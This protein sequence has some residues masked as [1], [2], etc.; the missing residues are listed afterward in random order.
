[1]ACVSVSFE[2]ILDGAAGRVEAE[3]ARCWLQ[4]D[5]RL[6]YT[7]PDDLVATDPHGLDMRVLSTSSVQSKR[8]KRTS[9]AH[10][11]P[12]LQDPG[13]AGA[14]A[15]QPAA[16]LHLHR[17]TRL[18]PVGPHAAGKPELQRSSPAVAARRGS[19]LLKR[20]AVASSATAAARQPSVNLYSRAACMTHGDAIGLAAR[21]KARPAAEFKLPVGWRAYGPPGGA[22][23]APV[24]P[25][26]QQRNA[27]A[28][29]A[30]KQQSQQGVAHQQD[31]AQQEQQ[32][33]SAEGLVL[34]SLQHVR[35]V[36]QGEVPTPAL[37][38][39]WL[40]GTAANPQAAAGWAG[41]AAAHAY[42]LGLCRVR[43]TRVEE[44]RRQMRLR[45]ALARG[46][47]QGDAPRARQHA[48]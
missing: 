8:R 45:L 41:A 7:P 47:P 11:L 12:A 23:P 20:K 31:S 29:R 9:G 16:R 43:V 39:R 32:Y 18:A 17:P 44:D 42:L 19:D 14:C 38:L 33:I 2:D 40:R 22:S 21:R 24:K 37:L 34:P 28:T 27:S 13:L 6:V 46:L 35:E 10:L 26:A 4:Q 3:A 5:P 25:M 1:M 48:G 30:S 15:A 36:V